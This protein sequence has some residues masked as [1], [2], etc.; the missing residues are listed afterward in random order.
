[1]D[2]ISMVWIK[3]VG[4]NAIFCLSLSSELRYKNYELY[5]KIFIPTTYLCTYYFIRGHQSIKKTNR[6]IVVQGD[7]ALF[8]LNIWYAFLFRNGAKNL[9]QKYFFV[10]LRVSITILWMM[11]HV[12]R[13]IQEWTRW[14]S[15]CMFRFLMTNV[16]EFFNNSNVLY[17][18]S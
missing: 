14:C 6:L 4:S 17:L 18:V 15:I 2:M 9:V 1:M 16:F 8:Y 10:L 13:L 3:K 12:K 5:I 11:Y 7:S